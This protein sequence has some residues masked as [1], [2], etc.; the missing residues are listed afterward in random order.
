L[1]IPLDHAKDLPPYIP[2]IIAFL[3]VAMED[4]TARVLIYCTSDVNGASAAVM[5]YMCYHHAI[6]AVE[7]SAIMMDR[8]PHIHMPSHD[9]SCQI[10]E[11]FSHQ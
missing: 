8:I 1:Q 6:T 4:P 7:A 3:D 2:L 10:D 5:A 11:Y 9:Y